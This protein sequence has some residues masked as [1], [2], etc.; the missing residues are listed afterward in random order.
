MVLYFSNSSY[1][2]G[3]PSFLDFRWQYAFFLRLYISFG[4]NQ[5]GQFKLHYLCGTHLFMP[6]IIRFVNAETW[7][8][9]SSN[10]CTTSL[11]YRVTIEVMQSNVITATIQGSALILLLSPWVPIVKRANHTGWGLSGGTRIWE[12]GATVNVE[13]FVRQ[14]LRMRSFELD[15]P[16][17]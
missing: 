8:L 10:Q 2:K 1:H 14:R 12:C 4:Q 7:S 5:V 16:L 13:T 17:F 6:F 9:T 3:G 11:L 15:M